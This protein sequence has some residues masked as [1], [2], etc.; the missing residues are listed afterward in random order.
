MNGAEVLLDNEEE[1][2]PGKT[3]EQRGGAGLRVPGVFGEFSCG[4]ETCMQ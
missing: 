4:A 2:M 1:I 3:T